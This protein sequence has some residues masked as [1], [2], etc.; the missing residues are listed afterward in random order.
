MKGARKNVGKPG[1]EVD[2]GENEMNQE[3]NRTGLDDVDIALCKMNFGFY[4]TKKVGSVERFEFPMLLNVC[5]YHLDEK[6]L[7]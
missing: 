4:D 3:Q 5:G 2:G 1:Q 6:R 7:V